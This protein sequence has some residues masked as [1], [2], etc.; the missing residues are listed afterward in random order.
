MKVNPRIQETDAH[1]VWSQSSIRLPSKTTL[2]KVK[3]KDQVSKIY[4]SYKFIAW[5]KGGRFQ[6]ADMYFTILFGRG[7]NTH[8]PCTRYSNVCMDPPFLDVY[9][10]LALEV[11]LVVFRDLA[12]GHLA[13]V[14]HC[15]EYVVTCTVGPV[16]PGLFSEM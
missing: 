5:R 11:M 15:M 14:Q 12:C 10:D 4:S 2:Q 6:K 9:M 3:L 1:A 7:P 16:T 8:C 13:C